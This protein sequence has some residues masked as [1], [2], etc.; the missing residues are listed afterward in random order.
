[1]F[2]AEIDPSQI[3]TLSG[4]TGGTVLMQF[5]SGGDAVLSVPVA[6]FITGKVIRVTDTGRS[7]SAP[8]HL[9]TGY[10]CY[11]DS[12]GNTTGIGFSGSNAAN[13]SHFALQYDFYYDS[14]VQ[15]WA[16]VGVPFNTIPA[17][18]QSDINFSIAAQILDPSGYVTIT[19][20]RLETI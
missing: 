14:V 8:S 13:L 9:T 2:L 3:A 11:G 4:V 5:A 17:S 19:R 20:F 12:T 10:L 7:K 1:M 6:P 16:Q 18:T 15:K